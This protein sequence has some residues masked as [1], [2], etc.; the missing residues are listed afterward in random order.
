MYMYVSFGVAV[1]GLDDDDEDE[2]PDIYVIDDDN[3]AGKM[4]ICQIRLNRVVDS[5]IL[6]AL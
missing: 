3:N 4:A 1:A 2:L 6:C 5:P